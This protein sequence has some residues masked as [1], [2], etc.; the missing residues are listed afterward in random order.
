MATLYGQT[1]NLI[2]PQSDFSAAQN[3]NRGWSATQTFRIKKGDVDNNSVATKFQIG[4]PLITLD[5][6]CDDFFTY[7]LL[8]KI[9]AVQTIEGGW[10]DVTCE[11]VGFSGA[12]SPDDPP[13]DPQP[14]YAKRGT[15]KSAPLSEHPKWKPLADDQKFAL[16]LLM[17]GDS[18]SKPDFTGV[19]TYDDNGIFQA[20]KKADGTDIVLAGDAIEFAKRI[21][22]GD[23][24]YE[25]G[26]YDYTHRW[27][28]NEG[29]SAAKM[30]LLGKIVSA[31]SG[32]PP[33]PGAGRN[34]L[35]VGVNEEQHGSGDFR[36]TNEL[37]YLLSDE[38]GWDSFLY[39]Q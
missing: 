35:L 37:Q 4:T 9:T 26:T 30:N 36:F 38:G 11:F 22:Q 10:T 28:D 27:E 7:L 21:A 3:E 15:L 23:T 25:F 8:S 5:P 32:D 24:T 34:W 1:A 20:W 2:I 19:G 17:S 31:P 16:G 12:T 33:T 6:H 29:V 18:V 39:D 13:V 14:T